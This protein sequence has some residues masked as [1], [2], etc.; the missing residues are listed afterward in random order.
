MWPAPLSAIKVLF[1]LNRYNI[2]DI[3]L[4]YVRE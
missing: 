3:A 4:S 1:F 2:L